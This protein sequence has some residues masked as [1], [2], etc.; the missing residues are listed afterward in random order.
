MYNIQI[1]A[2]DYCT[3]SILNQIILNVFNPFYINYNHNLSLKN[4]II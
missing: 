4:I 2:K 1:L 3:L